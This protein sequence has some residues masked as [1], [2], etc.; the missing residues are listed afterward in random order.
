[1]SK[2]TTEINEI[3]RDI[4]HQKTIKNLKRR[5]I[6]KA[7]RAAREEIKLQ[8]QYGISRIARGEPKL[9]GVPVRAMK[10]ALEI[11]RPTWR[12]NK[13]FQPSGVA[14][15]VAEICRLV[16]EKEKLLRHWL[17]WL[18]IRKWVLT[19]AN[20]SPVIE[21]LNTNPGHD[22]EWSQELHDLWCGQINASHQ[23]V[24]GADGASVH[25]AQQAASRQAPPSLGST[26]PISDRNVAIPRSP[27]RSG[28]PSGELKSDSSSHS[29]DNFGD[30]LSD[31]RSHDQPPQPGD[32][33]QS[34][35]PLA[36][37]KN[38]L[39]PRKVNIPPVE[40]TYF[41]K[42]R[43]NLIKFFR[44]MQSGSEPQIRAAAQ[45]LADDPQIF[46][47]I[48]GVSQAHRRYVAEVF[49]ELGINIPGSGQ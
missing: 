20:R 19:E 47:E 22:D 28:E 9:D 36:P 27:D 12:G 18:K 39:E 26:A 33:G 25:N 31:Y 16:P 10:C 30:D 42:G 14:N 1:M 29:G 21:W 3:N 35:S 48:C 46:E 37:T 24:T 44:A 41:R 43:W 8:D 6:N 34:F 38:H 45:I 40:S 13:G 11:V 5:V 17:E 49:A 7:E 23:K 15:R 32:E 4:K 2:A